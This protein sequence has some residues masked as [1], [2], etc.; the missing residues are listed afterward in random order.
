MIPVFAGA[1]ARVVA[2][3]WLGFGRSDKPVEGGVCTY[4]FHR[5]M[6][7]AFIRALDLT[8]ITLVVQDWGGGLLGLTVPMEMPERFERLIVMNTTIATG[9]SP[10]KGFETWKQFNRSQPDLDIAAL[11]KRASPILSDAEA[12][13]YAAPFPDE[14]YKA[15]VR[16]FPELV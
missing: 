1:G 12:N 16:R 5:N 9:V 7:L 3:D 6:L 8:N 4:T 13:A 10:G 14:T 2:P 15:G 11:M